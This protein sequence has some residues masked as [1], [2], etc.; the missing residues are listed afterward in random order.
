MTKASASPVSAFFMGIVKLLFGEFEHEEFKKFVRL[1]VIFGCIIGAYW[2][3]RVLKNAFFCSLIG[4]KALAVAKIVSLVCLLPLVMFYTKLIE[5]YSREKML[6]ILPGIYGVLTL[7]FSGLIYFV[8]AWGSTDVANACRVGEVSS[9]SWFHMFLGYGFYVFVESYG[10]LVVALFWAFLS[11]ITMPESAKKGFPLVVALGQLGSIFGPLV[12]ARI[13]AWIGHPTIAPAVLVTALATFAIIPA[14]KNF[15]KLTPK[16]LTVTYGGVAEKHSEEEP[17]FFEGL[18]LLVKH[19]YLLGILFSVFVFEFISTIID[20]NFQ[21]AAHEQLGSNVGAYH[22]FLGDYG[23]YVNA[24]TLLCLLLGVSNIT[25]ILG[26]SVALAC[27][28]L[29]VGGALFGF[30]TFKSLNVLLWLMIGSK[31]INYALNGPTMKQLYI[32]T[33]HDTKF[34]AQAWIE[35][36]GSRGSK[37]AASVLNLLKAAAGPAYYLLLCNYIGFGLVALWFFVAVYL[38]RTHHK[39]I[40]ANKIVC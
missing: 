3:L 36:F 14:F 6:Y 26:V 38:G 15:L 18:I 1:G 2:T 21:G 23:A 5:R 17:G 28:P 27:V 34:K 22:A 25:R 37:S 11:E 24:A 31:A 40:K 30:L 29:V 33:T 7:I 12:V 10:S 19:G 20:F 13:P 4:S 16:H 9:V 32:P 8:H 39:A 35:T